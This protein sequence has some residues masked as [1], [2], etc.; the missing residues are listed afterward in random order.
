MKVR[1]GL[2]C[3]KIHLLTT[4][5]GSKWTGM[6]R[7]KKLEVSQVFLTGFIELVRV[8]LNSF[9]ATLVSWDSP[10]ESQESNLQ[11]KNQSWRENITLERSKFR[12]NPSH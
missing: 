3:F 8:I 7:A 4:L 2:V 10:L 1:D 6:I 11:L 5:Q 12:E 9:Y